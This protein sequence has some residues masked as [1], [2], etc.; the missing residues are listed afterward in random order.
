ML[1]DGENY[2][3]ISYIICALRRMPLG[4]IKLKKNNMGGMNEE[5]QI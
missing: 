2:I 3:M 5:F 4:V 1:F